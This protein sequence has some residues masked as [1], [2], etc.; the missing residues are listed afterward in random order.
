MN[1]NNLIIAS[2]AFLLMVGQ[3]SAQDHLWKFDENKGNIA[4]DSRTGKSA[5]NGFLNNAYWRDLSKVG[6]GAAVRLTGDDNS[7]VTFGNQ[8]ANFGT[9]DFTVA[10]WVQ[11]R[12]NCDLFDLLGNRA[13][14]GYYGN[15]FNIRMNKEGSV[16]AEI[17]QDEKGT[18][19]MGIRAV[20][21]G[22]N[23]GQWHH[24]AVVRSKGTL[25][26]YIDCAFS[27][28]GA[29]KVATNLNS[30]NPLKL[31]RSLVDRSVRRFSADALFDD[32][33]IY[34]SALSYTQIKT[35][36]ECATNE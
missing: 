5:V 19:Y 15:Y 29:N 35:L 8:V 28:Y 1:K 16:T 6:P 21:K 10:F 34:Y 14:S 4:Y 9:K 11:T 20:Q 33:A 23:D 7:F 36:Y 31:G 3:I 13:D 26:I 27:I 22:L 12:E 24:I 30:R 18:N 2:F 25:S 32:L 17:C